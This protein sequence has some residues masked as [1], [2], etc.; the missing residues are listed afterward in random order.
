[1][2]WKPPSATDLSRNV[3]VIQ[4][5]HPGDIFG[6]GQT[7]VGYVFSDPAGN[8]AVCSFSVHVIEG[9][10]I[11]KFYFIIM[12]KKIN[13]HFKSEIRRTQYKHPI[14]EKTKDQIDLELPSQI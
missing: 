5:Q 9:K 8:I 7:T 6:I 11:F 4:N 3:T 13:I 10:L 12:C 2:Y 14:K 1:M